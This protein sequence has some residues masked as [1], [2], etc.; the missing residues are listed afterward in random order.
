MISII[1]CSRKADIPQ[2]LKDNIAATIGCEYE[3]CVIDNSR[4][5]YNIFTAYNEGVRRAKGEV[6]C[7]MH[8]DIVF[9]SEEWGKMV[10]EIFS[11]QEKLGVVGVTGGQFFP[12]TPTSYWEGGTGVGQII[13]GSIVDGKYKTWMNGKAVETGD[14]KYALVD[15]V[16]VDGLWMCAPKLLFEE[17]VIRWD[18]ENFDSFHCYDM[19]I[20]LQT[21]Q[22][23]YRVAVIGGIMIEH[24]S[25]GNT[26]MNYCIQSQKLF[27]KWKDVLPL[28]R[29]R[30]MSE[31]EIEERTRM[32]TQMRNYLVQLNT[33]QQRYDN[34]LKSKAYR[35]GKALLKPFKRLK[36]L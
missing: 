29:G 20:C 8:E 17:G 21:I 3:L 13:Q 23:G 12:K 31:Q 7:F 1:I 2:D 27:D 5:E 16:A 30:E 15:V 28:V 24:Q 19:D 32:V 11:Q 4:N 22:A 10:E 34:V 14:A 33:V 36:R 9:H 18:S 25:F 35:L 6:L 26:D